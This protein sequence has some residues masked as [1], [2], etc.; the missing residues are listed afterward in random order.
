MPLP[1]AK[2]KGVK[3]NRILSILQPQGNCIVQSP[4]RIFWCKASVRFIIN[5]KIEPLPKLL[6]YIGVGTYVSGV[7]GTKFIPQRLREDVPANQ[8]VHEKK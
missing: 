5:N 1:R 8:R 2:P 6:Q 7:P 4:L 3:Y